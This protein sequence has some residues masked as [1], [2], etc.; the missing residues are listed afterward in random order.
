MSIAQNT[1]SLQAILETVNNLPNSGGEDLEAVI[2][3]Q[4][5]LIE[6]LSTT[7]DS[8]ASGSGG[9]ATEVCTVDLSS[10]EGRITRLSYQSAEGEFMDYYDEGGVGNIT[11]PSSISVNNGDWILLEILQEDFDLMTTVNINKLGK[12]DTG[13]FLVMSILKVIAPDALI[14]FE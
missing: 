12:I 10:T 1:I 5:A 2:A 13:S 7:L 3:E 14:S 8:K 9:S 6:E 11:F 4:N